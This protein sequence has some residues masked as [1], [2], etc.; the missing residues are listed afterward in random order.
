MNR[1]I[2]VLII[3]FYSETVIVENKWLWVQN[4]LR[5]DKD[6]RAVAQQCVDDDNCME[7]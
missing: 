5:N 4:K 7:V 2:I 6:I 3:T 1:F